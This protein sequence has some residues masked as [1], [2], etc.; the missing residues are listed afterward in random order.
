LFATQV[1]VAFSRLC[2]QCSFVLALPAT[3]YNPTPRVFVWHGEFIM[4][5]SPSNSSNVFHAQ[6]FWSPPPPP[7]AAAAAAALTSS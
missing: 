7:A 5:I 1:D 2:S 6:P 4:L 3:A